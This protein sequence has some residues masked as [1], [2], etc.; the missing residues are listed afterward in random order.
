MPPPNVPSLPAPLPAV[1]STPP[2]SCCSLAQIVGALTISVGGLVLVGWA[3]GFQELTTLCLQGGPMVA[4]SAFC[5]ILSGSAL[6]FLQTQRQCLH[7]TARA[8][9]LAVGVIALL[10]LGEY[11]AGWNLGLDELLV[12]DRFT[13]AGLPPGRMAPNTALAFLLTAAALGLLSRPDWLGRRRPWILGG[14]GLA[15][16]MLGI[17]TMVG[18]LAGFRFFYSWGQLK[19]MAQATALLF[20]LLGAT[21]LAAA[22]EKNG[23]R[24]LLGLWS[25]LGLTVGIAIIIIVATATFNSHQEL[26]A[27][28]DWVLHTNNV[29]GQ[30]H[31]LKATLETE[32]S[33]LHGYLTTGQGDR[34]QNQA[35]AITQARKLIAE[36]RALT[37]DN[38]VQQAN[39]ARVEPLVAR[40]ETEFAHFIAAYPS[41]GNTVSN[42][43]LQNTE[44]VALNDQINANLDEMMAEEER[45]LGERQRQVLRLSERAEVILPIGLLLSTLLIIAGVL[46]LNAETAAR[47]SGLTLLQ[48]STDQLKAQALEQAQTLASLAQSEARFKTM[49]EEAPLGIALIDSHTGHIYEVNPRFAAIAGRTREELASIDWLKITHPDDVQADLDNMAALNAG[50]ISGFHME[51]RY[52]QPG[53]FP[54]WIG[55]TI[56]PLRV[57]DTA[58]PRHLCMIEDIS[59]RKRAE[60]ERKAAEHELR[61]KEERLALA[62]LHNGIGIWDWNLVTQEM[63]WDDSMFALY[64]IRREDFVGTEEAWRASL[65]PEDL[66]RGD[67]E[68]REAISGEK[69]FDTVFRVIWPNGEIHHIKA[70]AKV[71]RDEQGTPLRMLGTNIDITD[72]KQAEAKVN[73]LNAELEQRV[74]ERTAELQAT[75]TSLT[76]FK[77]ALDE[78]VNVTMT[79]THGNITY[80][81]DRVCALTQYSRAELLGHNHRIVNSNYHPGEFFKELWVTISAGRVWRGEIRNRAKDGSFHWVNTT[82]VPF[83]GPDGRPVQYIAIRNDI[84]PLKVAEADNQKLNTDLHTRATKLERVN[85]ELEAFSYTVAHDLR[86]PLRA[87]DGYARMA[88]EDLAALLDDNGRRLLNVISAE[89]KRMG[90]LIDDLL[91]FSRISRQQAEPVAINMQELAQ[92]VYNALIK[93]EPGRTV[94]FDLHTLPAAQGTPA[95]IRQVWENLISNTLKFT[96]KRPDARIEIGAQVGVDG[97]WVYHVKDNGVGFDMRHSNKLFG[98]FQRLHDNADYEGTGVGLALVQRI[99]QRHGGRIWAEGEVDKGACFYFTLPAP[100]TVAAEAGKSGI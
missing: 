3:L 40:R 5:F 73:A 54:V 62:T 48:E 16:L 11:V 19:P 25:T 1:A 60:E 80:A 99:L 43:P 46:R 89:A 84:T 61:E 21:V 57:A 100:E 45:L 58:H 64:H 65:H 20:I 30:L 87:I 90:R 85:K 86:A 24:R 78:H 51:K 72:H 27:A 67:Q 68:V 23:R 32:Q 97:V 22:R 14:L 41:S 8:C 37:A 92:E 10:T 49:F 28:T 34:L 77:S 29:T 76:D 35:K 95:M 88:L 75:N 33:N 69:P 56:A 6:L 98:V 31:Q 83:R 44:T 52:L 38:A 94:K 47:L 4:N 12:L 13:P 59:E 53:G 96:R 42:S 18:Y 2:R 79:D 66:G 15:V 93:A 26:K 39:L 63:V 55:M 9:A 70:V 82:I 17:T 74:A 36:L 81:N 7:R 71:F 91:A 50:K